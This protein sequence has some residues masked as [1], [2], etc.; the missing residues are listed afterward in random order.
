MEKR[1]YGKIVISYPALSRI[2]FSI[3]SGRQDSRPL[4]G[5]VLESSRSSKKDI[6]TCIPKH[7]IILRQSSALAGND[8]KLLTMKLATQSLVLVKLILSISQSN[9]N[10]LGL[11]SMTESWINEFSSWVTKMACPLVFLCTLL[12]SSDTIRLGSLISVIVISTI[13]STERPERLI[14]VE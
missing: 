5:D 10:L 2:P 13:S 1:L 9:R 3:R 7:E 11:Y 14:S 8:D 4:T 6:W 12:A